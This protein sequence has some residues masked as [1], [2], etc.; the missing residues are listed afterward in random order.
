M[1][2][3]QIVMPPK[4]DELRPGFVFIPLHAH[5][6]V[7]LISRKDEIV[8][9]LRE[10]GRKVGPVLLADPPV[11]ARSYAKRNVADRPGPYAPDNPVAI[12]TARKLNEKAR[13][14]GVV[15]L[16]AEEATAEVAMGKLDPEIER[17]LYKRVYDQLLAYASLRYNSM[18]FDAQILPATNTWTASAGG[19]ADTDARA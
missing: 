4:L 6:V 5:P 19:C 17:Q 1:Q 9:E 18:P 10:R 14:A 7:V 8:R 2:Q 15:F 13:Q 3:M 12:E 16:A 11:L